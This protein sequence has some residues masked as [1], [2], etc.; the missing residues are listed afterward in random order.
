MRKSFHCL[1][2]L[3]R[4][5]VETLVMNWYRYTD[6]SKY[7]FDFGLSNDEGK[8][9]NEEI[10][11]LGGHIFVVDKN[12]SIWKKFTYLFRL[13]YTLKKN[14]PYH[15]LFA[16]EQCFG[17]LSC[18]VAFLAGIPKRVTVAHWAMVYQSNKFIQ[19]FYRL[20]CQPSRFSRIFP[21]IPMF[22]LK[23]PFAYKL[24]RKEY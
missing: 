1:K 18:M 22:L 9:F 23:V 14:G 21:A 13:F 8:E 7:M 16:H 4:G 15:T 11:K 17:G 12:L 10:A 19:W 3:Y 5:G 6:T 20:L 2:S 24:H